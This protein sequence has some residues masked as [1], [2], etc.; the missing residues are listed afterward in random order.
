[1]CPV[2]IPPVPELHHNDL[3]NVILNLADDAIDALAQPIPF[4]TGEFFAS[5]GPGV[6]SQL[7]KAL[8]D[9]MDVLCGKGPEI[10]GHGFFE[11]KVIFSHAPSD[12]SKALRRSSP[13]L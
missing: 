6:F 1:M 10:F 9:A 13:V 8:Q 12:P 5:R 7:L 2:K 4:L 11:G 3:Q